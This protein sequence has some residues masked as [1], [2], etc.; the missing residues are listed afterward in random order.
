M[1]KHNKLVI[2]QRDKAL[3]DPRVAQVHM[4]VTPDEHRELRADAAKHHG[5]NVSALLMD[6]WRYRYHG[7]RRAKL[8]SK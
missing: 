2:V 8:S 5:G 1:S 7:K 4:R 6:A 3:E